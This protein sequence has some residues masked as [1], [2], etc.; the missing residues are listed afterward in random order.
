MS[1]ILDALKK[2]DRERHSRKT[3]K[4][5][6]AA[7]IVKPDSPRLEKKA[8]KYGAAV[9]LSALVATAITYAVLTEFV[10]P[11]KSSL[12]G[13][14]IPSKSEQ[15]VA[16]ASL[17][18]ESVRADR[19]AISQPSP[20]IPDQEKNKKT[21]VSES[22]ISSG[23]I[24]KKPSTQ[25]VETAPEPKKSVRV[26][27]GEISQ[28]PRSIRDQSKSKRPL[29]STPAIPAG[30][31]AANPP[32][33]K[34]EP[35]PKP[36]ESDHVDRGEINQPSRSIPEQRE[37]NRNQ[38]ALEEKKA[39][40]P[41]IP[42]EAAGAPRSTG[43]PTK[44]A[45]SSLDPTAQSL[46]LSAILWSDNPSERRAAINGMVLAEGATIEG[47]KVIAINPSSVRLMSNKGVFE[48]SINP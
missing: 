47:V 30:V 31:I 13:P 7:E 21:P 48:L 22:A 40:Q 36:Q 28:P 44:A 23:V 11:K 3:R 32:T 43:E 29:V 45:Q 39:A 20:I 27:R 26:D 18:R 41:I 5:D 12:P 14:A 35:A 8:L 25:K 46:K 10:I 37:S 16:T 38:T 2:L 1:L 42:R 24:E 9:V 33:Q 19:E 6:I 17:P 34:A 4:V 15:Q